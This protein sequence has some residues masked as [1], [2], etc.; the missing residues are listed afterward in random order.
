[1]LTQTVGFDDAEPE[2]LIKITVIV[3]VASTVPQPPVKGIE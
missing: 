2:V 1:V 3:P